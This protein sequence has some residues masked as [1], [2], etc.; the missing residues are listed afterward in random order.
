MRLLIAGGGTGGHLYPGLAIAEEVRARQGEVLF[1]G[2]ARGLESR[3]VPA[4]GYRLELISVSGLKR[5]GLVARLRGLA[6]LP[7]ALVRSLAILRSFR[8]DVVLGVGGYASGPMLVAATLAR[9]PGAIMEQ[10][11]VPG[12]TNKALGPLVRA[13]FT[14]FDA[15][16]AAFPAAKIV[17]T[18]NPVRRA[19]L[20]AAN[21]AGP[22]QTGG[23]GRRVLVVGGSQGARAVNDLVVAAAEIWSRGPN[24]PR[25]V[26]Q[27]GTADEGRIKDTYA[28]RGLTTV[29]VRAFIE[30]MA[31]AC[32]DTDLVVARAGALTLAELAILHV[33]AILIPLPTAADDHQTK[34]AATFAAAGA[35]LLL[36]QAETTGSRLATEVT[37]L[38]ADPA[39]RQ[40]M[41]TAMS[42]LARPHAAAEIVDRLESL[43]R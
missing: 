13:V 36:P 26:H 32:A 39:R 34:N 35:A 42:T 12:F 1:V 41:S 6:R 38:L 33:P 21:A 37:H 31:A 14:A 19:F 5:V 27:T 18:G 8:P 17:Q 22:R 28:Q 3:V 30:D 24:P 25:L 9:R 15:A 11:T 23:P 40:A 43:R 20:A 16:N 29:T 4:A 7:A 10:N 2:T